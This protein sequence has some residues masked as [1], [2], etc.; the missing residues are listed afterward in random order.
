MPCV[1]SPHFYLRPSIYINGSYRE[2]QHIGNLLEQS[3][4]CADGAGSVAVSNLFNPGRHL[5]RAEHY[6]DLKVGAFKEGGT[7]VV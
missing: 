5:I 7:A 4:R 3:T 1:S 6:R 2:C